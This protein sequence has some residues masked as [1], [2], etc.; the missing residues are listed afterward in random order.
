MQQGASYALKT[1]GSQDSWI[2][3]LN[4]DIFDARKTLLKD[5]QYQR[6]YKTL[7]FKNVQ[8]QSNCCFKYTIDSTCDLIHNVDVY[9][10]K[11]EEFRLNDLVYSIEILI[12]GQRID[13]IYASQCEK[14]GDIETLLNTSAELLHSR[15]KVEYTDTYIIIPLHLAPFHDSNLVFPSCEWHEMVISIEGAFSELYNPKDFQIYAECYY[16]DE[17]TKYRLKNTLQEF[18]TY[19]NI[20]YYG[21]SHVLKKG[22]NKF[23]LNFNHPVHSIY[24]WGFDKTKIKRITL[25]LNDYTCYKNT[26][27]IVYNTDYYDGTL[28][29][30]EYSKKS[31][32]ISAEPVFIFFSD[33]TIYERPKSTINFSRLDCPILT[34][35]TEQEDEPEFYLNG[36]N[37]QGY[38]C[39]CG[40]FGLIYSK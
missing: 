29:P 35:E 3:S 15:R 14:K 23:K 39:S 40:M 18:P 30:L 1:Y 24:F 13:K 37:I 20:T 26:P 36:I 32:G 27:E 8:K 31:R 25:T 2:K 16:V 19:Q 34:I 12:G 7:D 6:V 33:T 17:Q 4:N 28:E 21:D 22:I 11:K 5:C 9:I 10:P 38:R